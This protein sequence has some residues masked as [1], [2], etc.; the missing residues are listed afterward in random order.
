LLTALA[1]L[2]C[3]TFDVVMIVQLLHSS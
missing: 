2:L 1:S 3:V